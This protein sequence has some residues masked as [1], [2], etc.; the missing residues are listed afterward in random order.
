MMGYL[1]QSPSG[2]ADTNKF[3]FSAWA[4]LPSE[5]KPPSSTTNHSINL[6][7]FGDPTQRF[8]VVRLYGNIENL[9]G[10]NQ[11]GLNANFFSGNYNDGGFNF[12]NQ[13][14]NAANG[15]GSTRQTPFSFGAWHHIFIAI[16]VS[17]S[18]AYWLGPGY[19]KTYYPFWMFQDGVSC[20]WQ[21]AG[22]AEPGVDGSIYAYQGGGNPPNQAPGHGS[23]K[24]FV[25]G[26]GI[27]LRQYNGDSPPAGIFYPDTFTTAVE[28]ADVQAWF[29]TFIN[30]SIPDN[31]SKFVK[32]TG[33]TGTPA[34]PSVA[35]SAFGQPSILFKGKASDSTFFINNGTGGAFAKTGTVIDFTP[36]PSY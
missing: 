25:N 32:I 4:R 36:G 13:I 29:G 30:P 22:Y 1:Q 23:T 35:A 6:F 19:P 3:S 8:S 20:G 16:D 24:F 33:S 11:F 12:Y 18:F 5:T 17:P 14:W 26:G 9:Y 28:F 21:D 10:F 31:F 7:M 2:I 15:N 27:S 34:D